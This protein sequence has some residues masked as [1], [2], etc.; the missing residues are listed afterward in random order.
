MSD[1]KNTGY[2]ALEYKTTLKTKNQIEKSFSS[3][4]KAIILLNS[5]SPPAIINCNPVAAEIFGYTAKEMIGRQVEFLYLNGEEYRNFMGN[6]DR[7]VESQGCLFIPDYNMKRGDNSVIRVEKSV[8]PLENESGRITGWVYVLRKKSGYDADIGNTRNTEDIMRW[9]IDAVPAA[10]FVKDI[11]GRYLLVNRTMCEILDVSADFIMGKTDIELSVDSE[12]RIEEAKKC[13]AHDMEVINCRQFQFIREERRTISDR[14]VR[15]FQTTRKPLVVD[16]RPVAV[17]GIS[18][19]ITDRKETENELLVYQEKLRSLAAELSRTED[20][21]RRRIA[22]ELHDRI[23]QN[24]A[25]AKLKLEILAGVRSEGE[26]GSQYNQVLELIDQ[27]L[28]DT[29]SLTFEI[30]P[31]I[32]YELGLGPALEWLGEQLQKQEGIE[33]EYIEDCESKS[34]NVEARGSIYQSVRELF[35]NIVKH[36][37]AQKV[38]VTMSRKGNTLNITVHDNGIGF[39]PDNI[40]KSGKNGGFGLFSVRERLYRLGGKFEIEATPGRG[41][42]FYLSFPL[43]PESEKERVSLNDD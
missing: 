11:N 35:V 33:F 39:D 27:T 3:C 42:K 6:L 7:A 22:T 8:M 28:Q 5:D 20:R 25:V 37:Q 10:V 12:T 15:W 31:P 13:M 23:G 26:M 2:S 40:N 18:V 1:N 14:E 32:L 29:Y 9:V 38:E 4:R 24:L 41:S 36:S 17:L 34:M 21:E 19:D 30:S 16:G 43:Q